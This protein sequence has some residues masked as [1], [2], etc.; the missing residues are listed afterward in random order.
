MPTTSWRAGERPKILVRGAGGSATAVRDALARRADVRSEPVAAPVA[1]GEVGLADLVVVVVEADEADPVHAVAEV[2]AAT[3]CPV[4]VAIG[5]RPER[6]AVFDAGADD[7]VAL[8][9]DPEELLARVSVR[10]AR[11]SSRVDRIRH[12]AL[13]IDGARRVVTLA[14][15]AVPLTAREFDLLE[16]LARHPYRAFSRE[17]L[18]DA[19]WRSSTAWQ[20]ARTVNEHVHRLR[21]KLGEGWVET[22]RGVGYRFVPIVEPGHLSA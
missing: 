6:F 16:H 19:V 1:S 15:D 21:R 18:L 20:Q 12:G 5:R 7:V 9:V 2:R 8:P 14:G 4:V 22:V 11:S 10:L 3:D 17:E 13:V